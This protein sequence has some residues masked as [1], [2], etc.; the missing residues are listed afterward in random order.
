MAA[1]KR[2]GAAK[3]TAA[4]KKIVQRKPTV[5]EDIDRVNR[6]LLRHA[7]IEDGIRDAHDALNEGSIDNAVLVLGMTVWK[8]EKRGM[9]PYVYQRPKQLQRTPPSE[10][11]PFASH[12]H[13]H[14]PTGERKQ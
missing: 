6:D 8:M 5:W 14:P 13:Y 9:K 11:V 7:V 10:S 12:H 3:R 2:K 1:A 4:P